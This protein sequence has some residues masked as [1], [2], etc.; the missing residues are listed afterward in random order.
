MAKYTAEM[1]IKESSMS[2]GQNRVLSKSIIRTMK[3]LFNDKRNNSPGIYC[4]SV[5]ASL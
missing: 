3:V 4:D 5:P 2:I 1:L